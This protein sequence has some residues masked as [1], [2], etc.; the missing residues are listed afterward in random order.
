MLCVLHGIETIESCQGEGHSAEFF[1]YEEYI[2]QNE[3]DGYVVFTSRYDP[4]IRKLL[5]QVRSH[6]CIFKV[7]CVSYSSVDRGIKIAWETKKIE[8]ERAV[9]ILT[10]ML[11]NSV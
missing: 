1:D 8:T 9:K 7:S 3:P 6:C 5:R 2:D 4:R 10:E 11:R